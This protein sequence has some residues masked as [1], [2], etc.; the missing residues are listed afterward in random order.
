MS[1]A[2]QAGCYLR[3]GNTQKTHD[4]DNAAMNSNAIPIFYACD[5]NFVKH[6]IVSLTSM[7]ENA[8]PT[9]KYRVHVLHTNISERMMEKALRLANDRFEITFENVSGYLEKIQDKLP[10]RHYYTKTTYFRLFIADMFPEYDKAIYIDSDTVVTGDIS[11]LYDTDIDGFYIGACV[12]QAM[13]QMDVYGTYAEKV[14]GI[15]RRVF[16]NAGMMLIN[17]DTWRKAGLLD[18]FIK[19]LGIY[20]FVVTQ[21][22]DYLNVIC[23]W[24]VKLLDQRWNT[25]LT[26][27]IVYDYDVSEA[28]VL[29]YIMT[30]KPWHYAD[31]RGADIYWSYAKKTEMYDEI[32]AELD[33]YTDGQREKDRASGE[34]LCQMA[35]NETN[36]EDN[37]LKMM[38]NKCAPDRVKILERID[39]YERSGRFDE[40][41]EDDPPSRVLMPDEIDYVKRTAIQRIKTRLAYGAARRFVHRLIRE[42]K[43]IIKEIKG[44]ENLKKLDTG[45]VITCNHFNA[46]DSFAVQVAYE[47]AK[48]K[49]RKL[50]RVI[51][52]GNYT[53]FPGFY[54]RLM[55]NCNTLP[56]SSNPKTMRKFMDGVRTHLDEGNLVL[57]YPEQ[58]MWWNY[59]KPK[60]LKEGAYYF[61]SKSNVP[62]LPMFITMQDSCIVGEDGFPTQEY[63]IHVCKPIYPD[64]STPHKENVRKMMEENSR[65]WRKVYEKEYG[66]PLIYK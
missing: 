33:S 50:W 35:I 5:D 30:N 47:A 13:A 37:F 26:E 15:D 22:E 29:H 40:D 43:L 28:N 44:I 11:K 31:C 52:E 36:K 6:T 38:M 24:H 16:F 23:K 55:R 10:I 32:K 64:S 18:E 9:R 49:G 17:C 48:Q 19:L 53:S 60:P 51:R 7:I 58:S 61:A 3:G 45:A 62:V 54:G 25:E 59:R 20:N 56:L 14:V 57:I 39:E 21:D 63:T 27:G 65:I 66:I 12:E 46:F 41:V 34:N 1:M 4:K 42:K 8:D 2:E